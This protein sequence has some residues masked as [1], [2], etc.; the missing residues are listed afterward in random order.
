M[1]VTHVSNRHPVPPSGLRPAPEHSPG[2]HGGQAAALV[3]VGLVAAAAVF[4]VLRSAAIHE[5]EPALG[6]TATGTDLPAESLPSCEP[7]LAD[8]DGY[9]VQLEAV[10]RGAAS[11]LAAAVDDLEFCTLSPALRPG[12]VRDRSPVV[13]A[14]SHASLADATDAACG[15]A[16]E[17]RRAGLD[18]GPSDVAIRHRGDDGLQIRWVDPGSA[19]CS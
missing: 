6:L 5:Q 13:L 19:D 1:G 12:T 15:L 4:T 8:G 9:T 14:A 3:I 17:L 7:S 2:H 18:P 10:A 11:P 16:D